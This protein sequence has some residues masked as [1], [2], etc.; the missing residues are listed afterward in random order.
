MFNVYKKEFRSLML[1]PIGFTV[2]SVMLV[3]SGM[4]I[5]IYNLFSGSVR[6]EYSYQNTA[7]VLLLAVPLLSMNALSKE[8]SGKTDTLIFSLPTPLYKVILGKYLA[9]I[10]IISI[11]LAITFLYTVILSFYAEVSYLSAFTGTLA[12]WL[13]ACALLA[14]GLFISSMFENTILCA[15][16]GFAVMLLIYFLPT[17]SSVLPTSAE[18]FV[19]VFTVICIL[20]GVLICKLCRSKNLGIIVGAISEVILLCVYF[21]DSSILDGAL[22]YITRA[23]S[24]MY[25]LDAFTVNNTISIP[26]YVYYITISALFVFF[27]VRAE[28]KRRFA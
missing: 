2:V 26:A 4:F 15:L 17:F 27:T 7:L 3:F 20:L 5:T 23:L 14:I 19:G 16:C 24:V 12:F 18:A 1:S 6:I 21:F 28:E 13:C 8:H 11:P 22:Y 25:Y 10:T 9:L